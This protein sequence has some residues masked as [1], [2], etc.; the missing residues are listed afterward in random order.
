MQGV[1][2]SLSDP[3]ESICQSCSDLWPSTLSVLQRDKLCVCVFVCGCVRFF[4]R[5]FNHFSFPSVLWTIR[6]GVSSRKSFKE[7]IITFIFF[8]SS[9]CKKSVSV[10]QL[11]KPQWHYFCIQK[12]GK[13]YIYI[14]LYINIYMQ[15]WLGC[16]N[17]PCCWRGGI[18]QQLNTIQT[19][20]SLGGRSW[21]GQQGA[22]GLADSDSGVE[23]ED[24]RRAWQQACMR[25]SFTGHLQR[26]SPP[27]IFTP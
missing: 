10:F 8:L 13:K 15:I 18:T 17:S 7:I 16:S 25:Q 27:P 4:D 3:P 9:K 24:H 14:S 21:K 2:P 5:S 12:W 1:E 6:L 23:V 19:H 22:L 26:N 20:R 11:S